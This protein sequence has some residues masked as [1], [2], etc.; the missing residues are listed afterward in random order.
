MKRLVA[1]TLLC[2]GALIAVDTSAQANE[3]IFVEG[4]LDSVTAEFTAATQSWYPTLKD[5]ARYL[6]LLLAALGLAWNAMQA[7]LKKE[8]LMGFM[9]LTFIQL[10]TIGFYMLAID[11]IDIWSAAVVN[12]FRE[13]ATDILPANNPLMVNGELELT[14]SSII[15]MGYDIWQELL[16]IDVGYRPHWAVLFALTGLVVAILFA[17]MAAY[18]TLLLLEG[19]LVIGGGIIFLGFAGTDWTIDIAKNYLMYILSFAV[20]MFAVYLIMAVGI[21]LLQTTVFD[22]LADA[23]AASVTPSEYGD[24]LMHAVFFAIAIPFILLVLSFGVPAIFQQ[25]AGNMGSASNFALNSVLT[26]TLMTASSV[27]QQALGKMGVFGVGTGMLGMGAHGTGMSAVGALS[28][29]ASFGEKASAYFK[30]AGDGATSGMKAG[31]TEAW[32]GVKES[33]SAPARNEGSFVNGIAN[34]FNPGA[35]GDAGGSASGS[36]N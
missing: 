29:N 14:P 34:H 31:F 26:T 17:G 24:I 16:G 21:T 33:M 7:L 10:F 22:P 11:N 15:S 8:D 2:S 4:L 35:A 32:S 1:V 28:D 19:M 27:G 36:G 30:G 18:M 6:L 5:Y 9:R 20:K 25:I 23:Q 3:T 13:I 12:T